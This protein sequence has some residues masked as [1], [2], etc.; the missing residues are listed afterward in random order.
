M[1]RSGAQQQLQE[2]TQLK[3]PKNCILLCG[4]EMRCILGILGL[5]KCTFEIELKKSY[6]V[7]SENV[8]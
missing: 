8:D 1:G 6:M 3:K 2:D 4:E 7:L 5:P